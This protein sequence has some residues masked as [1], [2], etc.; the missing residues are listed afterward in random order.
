MKRIPSNMTKCV[1]CGAALAATLTAEGASSAQAAEVEVYQSSRAGD[2]LARVEVPQAGIDASREIRLYPDRGY[3]TIVGIGGAFTESAADALSALSEEKRREVIEAYFSPRQG[4][5]SLTR[6][7]VGSCDFSLGS[8]TYAEVE[9]DEALEHFTIDPDRKLLLPLIK[10]SMA[11]PGADFKILA[12]PW[13]A[14]PW[15]KDNGAYFGGSLLPEYREVY[16]NYLSKY[17]DAYAA[18][19]V[20]IWGLTPVNEPEGNNANWESMHFSPEQM[21]DFIANHLGPVFRSENR[22]TKIFV[23]DQNR[24]HM[25]EWAKVVYADDAVRSFV[26]GMAVHWYSSTVDVCAEALDAVH[27]AYPDMQIMHTEGCIDALGDDEPMWSWLEAD[28][29]WREEATDWGVFWAPEEQKV[30]HPP[31]SPVY[32]YAGDIIGG[33]NHW[34]T[35]W[36]DWN[37]VLDTRGGP[38]HVKNF[39]GAPVLIDREK[40]EAFYTPLYYV[41]CHFSR[42]IR[43]DAVRIGIEGAEGDIEGTAVRNVDGSIVAVLL[44]R[45]LEEQAYRLVCGDREVTLLMPP[46]SLQTVALR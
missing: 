19:G 40:G 41:M 30:D 28:W 14:P 25:E 9:G 21:R 2:Q 15:M 36:I 37:M 5:Y 7:H 20:P 22:D 42:F 32:R 6:T 11:V 4:G 27:H 8:Y 17:L 24:D 12:S 45:G 43:P 29:Y 38:N 13:T 39:C 18:E 10:D 46:Q 26:D 31:Y 1:V 16:V 33:L 23:F 35:G 3:Q 34:M 44:N